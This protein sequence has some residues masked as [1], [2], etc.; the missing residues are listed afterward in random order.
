MTKILLASHMQMAGGLK[1]TL[2]YICP[3]HDD[4]MVLNA[5]EKNVPVEEEL[6]AL[7]STV[8]DDDDCLIF[9]DL[10]GGSVNQAAA[11]Q[12]AGKPNFHLIAGMN[13]PLVLSLI[14]TCK[15]G[16]DPDAIRMAIEEARSQM[17]YVNDV[18]FGNQDED[19]DE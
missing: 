9:T 19:E 12:I 15:N 6:A 1:N 4:I 11:I 18:L 17:V 10:L 5:Y 13:L 7:L 2:N 3:D 8:G 16:V 14:L